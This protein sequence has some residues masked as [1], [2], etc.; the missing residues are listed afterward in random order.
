MYS[1]E[2]KYP[3]I[4]K[5]CLILFLTYMFIKHQKI[6]NS[7]K[8]LINSIAITCFIIILDYIIIKKHPMPF[9]T[10]YINT[11]DSRPEV[12]FTDEDIEEIIN[13]YDEDSDY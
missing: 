5:Y 7:E 3:P 11:E 12:E 8:N 2:Y 9:D 10:K 4:Y 13:S 6:L 1:M